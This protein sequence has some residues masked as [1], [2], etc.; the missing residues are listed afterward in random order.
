MK[1]YVW[2]VAA[3]F[4]IVAPAHSAL[5]TL[6][7]GK[8]FD[9]GATMTARADSASKELDRMSWAVGHWKVTLE[10]YADGEVANTAS[11][12]ADITFMN[13][14]HN[15]MERFY[16]EDFDGAGHE[17]STLS[18]IVYSDAQ[19]RWGIGVA[20][21][22]REHISVY[23]GN[24]VGNDLVLYNALRRRGG[25]N[26]TY[27]RLT[28]HGRSDDAFDVTL[29]TSPDNES[30]EPMVA[31]S[32]TRMSED[33]GLFTSATGYGEP[34]PDVPEEARQFDFLV[35]EASMHNKMTFPNGR[36]AEWDGTGTAVYM[37]NGHCVMEYSWYD[38]DPNLPDAA[39]T[40]VRL[41]NRQM[42]RWECMYT[43]NRFN[44]ILYF[45][46]VMEGEKIV[47]HQFEADATDSPINQWTF[48]DWSR[49]GY[50]W[51]GNNSRDRGRTWK[52]TWI[53]TAKRKP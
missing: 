4:G 16:T 41:W 33:D 38:V 12:R 26:L 20:D 35:G 47:L 39:T 7:D 48:H 29:A 50:G 31:R 42:R 46:G 18:F 24:F 52:K 40:I 53:I 36:V 32:Y 17:L 23:D 14:G 6:R 43:N 34:A 2:L 3:V 28:I 49:E 5:A 22:W 11:G 45:G 44:S 27:Y 8:R 1:T 21:S 25:M 15:M 10:T 19:A 30:W 13:R 51:Y 9:P 37:M